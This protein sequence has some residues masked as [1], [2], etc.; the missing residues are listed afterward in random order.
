MGVC[1][2]WIRQIEN[3]SPPPSPPKVKDGKMAR[4]LGSPAS[5]SLISRGWGFVVPFLIFC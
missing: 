1:S 2:S 5:S 4:V 3:L